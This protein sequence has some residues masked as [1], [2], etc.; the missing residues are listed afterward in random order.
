MKSE[1]VETFTKHTFMSSLL[2]LSDQIRTNFENTSKPETLPEI[3]ELRTPAAGETLGT[4]ETSEAG[5]NLGT[6][7]TLETLRVLKSHG[8][9]GTPEVIRTRRTLG[10]NETHGNVAVDIVNCNEGEGE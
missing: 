6:P 3:G 5:R 4:P 2:F 9:L 1:T 8:M 7:R 10:M